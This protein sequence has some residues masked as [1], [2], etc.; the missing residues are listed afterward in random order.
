MKGRGWGCV[1]LETVRLQAE[2]T[3]QRLENVHRI[4]F[5]SLFFLHCRAAE[6][7]A[8]RF[9]S[10]KFFFRL[11]V[12]HRFP[13]FPYECLL[14]GWNFLLFFFHEHLL[15]VGKWAEKWMKI[16]K[17]NG[18]NAFRH[19]LPNKAESRKWFSLNQFNFNA[20]ANNWKLTLRKGCEGNGTSRILVA[21]NNW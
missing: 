11:K 3:Q 8:Y 18:R 21:M 6:K 10:K 1:R 13:S 17:K 15:G 12:Y 7:F 5:Y 4:D 16:E 2:S 20:K 19:T 14:N 9:A